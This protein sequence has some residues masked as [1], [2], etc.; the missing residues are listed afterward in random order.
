MQSTGL[1]HDE[2]R[3]DQEDMGMNARLVVLGDRADR[4]VGFEFARC[5]SAP[6]LHESGGRHRGAFY[7]SHAVPETNSQ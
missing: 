5:L 6:F 4:E 3:R 2:A 1:K 7:S